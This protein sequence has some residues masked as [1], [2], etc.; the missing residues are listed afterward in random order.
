MA[1]DFLDTRLAKALSHPLR[2]R[3]LEVLAVR[4][5]ASPRELA[6]ELGERLP[7]VS[8]HVRILADLEC[9]EPTRTEPRRGAI[10]HFYRPTVAPMVRDTEWEQLP[11]SVRRSLAGGTAARIVRSLATAA[12]QGGFDDA[13]AHATWMP[14]SLDEAGRRELAELLAGLVE[15]AA[16]LQTESDKRSEGEPARSELALL[17]FRVD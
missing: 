16:Q 10:E 11:L 12:S 9:I 3:I 8:Y 17:H 7:N 4:G 6:E 14:L 1:A 15:R 5:E 2:Q 13:D